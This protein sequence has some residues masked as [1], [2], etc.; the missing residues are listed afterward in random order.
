MAANATHAGR[1]CPMP[2]PWRLAQ[3]LQSPLTI[4]LVPSDSYT[5]L[6]LVC[7]WHL[8][9]WV[10]H[11][12]SRRP[13]PCLPSS[14]LHRDNIILIPPFIDNPIGT[15]H[16]IAPPPAHFRRRSSFMPRCCARR[17]AQLQLCTRSALPHPAT[18][19]QPGPGSPH[20]LGC[21]QGGELLLQARDLGFQRWQHAGVCLH[22]GQR[23]PHL[24]GLVH[25][26][27]RLVLCLHPPAPGWP[28]VRG[29][30]FVTVSVSITI[31]I[32]IGVST[33]APAPATPRLSS[34]TAHL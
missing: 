27:L 33:S 3:L 5:L 18:A 32:S 13:S 25:V 26:L 30:I 15:H 11:F 24:A 1:C 12:I 22:L 28:H 34:T 16:Q 19:A 14:R 23:L 4:K 20:E 6:L 29:T 7:T 8:F 10:H 9:H 2:A 17:L 31:S 21:V